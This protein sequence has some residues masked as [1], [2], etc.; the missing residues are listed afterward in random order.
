MKRIVFWLKEPLSQKTISKLRRKMYFHSVF[1]ETVYEDTDIEP[2]EHTLYIT[3]CADLYERLKE[4]GISAVQLGF[5]TED[6][7]SF[8]GS[9]YYITDPEE[10]P[11][12]SFSLYYKRLNNIPVEI[13]RTKRLI[14][15]E[16]TESDV[17]AFYEMYKNPEMT[18]YTEPLYDDIEEEKK[19]V[20]EYREKVYNL[21]SPGIWT[22]IRKNDGVIIGRAGIIASS[23]YDC[24]IGFA[25][26]CE[27]Q[28][29]GYAF[30]AVSKIKE[31]AVKRYGVRE[32]SALVMPGNVASQTLLTKTGFK[33]ISDTKRSGIEYEVWK[34]DYIAKC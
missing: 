31:I 23:D 9:K 27:Y 26:G 14:I 16:T 12:E 29:Q 34:Y 8:S 25:V 33:K 22:L 17:D 15:R 5:S 18:R 13:T 20:T 7:N 6:I 19:Y 2:K 1:V 4:K 28:K 30:E 10:I 32:I 21:E 11:F 3:P 24:E